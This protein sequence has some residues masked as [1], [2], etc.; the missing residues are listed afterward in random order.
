MGKKMIKAE[1]HPELPVEKLRWRCDPKLF[2]FKTTDELTACEGIIGQHRAENAIQLGLEV[3]GRGYNIFVTG[4][5]GTGRTFTIKHLLEKLDKG[6]EAPDDILYVNNFSTP[7]MPRA[8]TLPAGKGCQFKTDIEH[9]VTSLL[10]TI[11]GIFAS[12]EYKQR[13]KEIVEIYKQKQ[14]EIIQEFEK[15]VAQ[16]GFVLVQVQ[17]GPYVKPD[18]QPVLEEKPVG[19]KQLETLV[20]EQKFPQEKLEQLKKAY[21]ELYSQMETSFAANKEVIKDMEESLESQ[22]KKLLVPIIEEMIAE[23][24]RKYTYK[25]VAIYLKEVQEDVIAHLDF[26]REPKREEPQAG[27]QA[28]FGAAPEDPLKNYRVN[29]LVDNSQTEGAPIIIET[30]P[31][32]RNLFGTIERVMERGGV[33]KTDFTMIKAGSLLRANGGYLVMNALDILL[34]PGAWP[35]LKRTLKFGQVEIQSF[36]PF[37]FMA[38]TGLKPEPIEAELKVVLIGEE[39]LY[40]L[41]YH[42]DED[43]KKVFKIKA[44]FDSVMPKDD[45][46]ICEYAAFIR[47]ITSEEKLLAFDPEGTSAVIEFAVRLAGKHNKITTRFAAVSDLIREASYWAQK[48]KAK[49]VA[50]SHVEKAV[51]EWKKRHSLTEDKIQEMIEEGDLLIDTKGAKVG[52]VNGLSVYSIGEYS[53]GKPTRI[54]AETSLGRSGVINIEREAELSGPTHSKGVLILTGY[55]QGKYAQD[56]PL[57]MN[58]S[59]CFEQSYAGVDGDSAS[60]TEI[61]AILSSLAGAPIRQDLAITGSVNQKG[62]IQPI[63]GVNQKIE[64]HFDVCKARRLTGTQGV[65]IPHQN[66]DEL[67]LKREVVKAV[68]AGR[69]H[70]YAIKT[71]DEGIEILTGV[72]AGVRK[73]DGEFEEETINYLVDRKL[74]KLAESWRAYIGNDTAS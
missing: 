5:V 73:K 74:K 26:F 41:L 66:A 63:G 67:M 27:P 35:A 71:I 12:E 21:N 32:Y 19:F 25:P 51:K 17:M 14:A 54:T 52:Q 28:L 6:K 37:Y 18:L 29:L 45:K 49:S 60:S 10:K 55:L 7:D 43:F 4:L 2:D 9:L 46:I 42:R 39:F 38:S 58:A 65:L 70:I 1:P 59:I 68:E 40:Q 31:S 33:W 11:S 47:K 34:E 15:K 69:F 44:E 20:A 30:S 36:D 3:K 48:A 16:E 22:D 56:K 62:E 13:R 57:V 64:G 8:I 50:A 24:K 61:Y 53:F 23:L 72:K